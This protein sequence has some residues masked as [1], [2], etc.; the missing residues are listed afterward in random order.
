MRK[1]YPVELKKWRASEKRI[2]KKRTQTLNE[3]A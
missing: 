2:V 1:N 3:N